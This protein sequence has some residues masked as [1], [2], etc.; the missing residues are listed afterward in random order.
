ML[1]DQKSMNK[2]IVFW[3]FFVIFSVLWLFIVMSVRVN[4][5]TL[6]DKFSLISR[7]P[8]YYLI[9]LF[10]LL[11]LSLIAFRLKEN[12]WSILFALLFIIYMYIT[13]W[14]VEPL[15]VID[16]FFHSSRIHVV[17]ETA[18][19]A[20]LRQYYFDYPGVVI[21]G[22]ALTSVTS[23]GLLPFVKFYFPIMSTMLFYL[24]YSILVR[25]L[26]G[27]RRLGPCLLLSSLFGYG[28]FHF[29][30]MAIGLILL[31]LLLW[32]FVQRKKNARVYLVCFILLVASLTISH[33]TTSAFLLL[34]FTV[35][36]LIMQFLKFTRNPIQYLAEAHL[37]LNSSFFAVSVLSWAI[38]VSY[39]VPGHIA[40]F[41]NS[42]LQ[43]LFSHPYEATQKILQPIYPILEI[44]ILRR[45]F[46]VLSGI[47]SIVALY[48]LIRKYCKSQ[49][50]ERTKLILVIATISTGLILMPLFFISE[51][52]V[53]GQVG[54][55]FGLLGTS[56]SLIFWNTNPKTIFCIFLIV[57]LLLIV[58]AFVSHYSAEQ[59]D[60]MRESI[61]SGMVFTSIHIDMKKAK[62]ISPFGTQ[63]FFWSEIDAW[64]N[65]EYPHY[66]ET[67]YSQMRTADYVIW[68]VD[69]LYYASLQA[70]RLPINDTVYFKSHLLM[71]NSSDFSLIY[72]SGNY[73]IFAR[74]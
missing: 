34:T 14:I 59:Y 26:G 31:P 60:I 27:S 68:R 24:F 33:P 22:F 65:I 18:H 19:L 28:G 73:Q 43:T 16:T 2:K 32:L 12:K 11:F 29:S 30:P 71:T 48:V 10:A 3:C 49:K 47:I 36:I 64:K 51:A 1:G 37:E 72:S 55:M 40:L 52:S 57:S 20:D 21:L 54:L 8:I 56:V 23:I 9:S 45:F 15:R 35:L 61:K 44:S 58:P 17:S 42:V 6:E 70:E 5:V 7:M 4:D 62:I 46:V 63:L 53:F 25:H 41:V 13:P 50:S 38:F 74:R 66:G 69:G 67:L 39:S